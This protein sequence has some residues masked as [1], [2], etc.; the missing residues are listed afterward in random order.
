MNTSPRTQDSQA[1]FVSRKPASETEEPEELIY[2]IDPDDLAFL[3]KL[4]IP[5]E[6]CESALSKTGNRMLFVRE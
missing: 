3:I 6:K 4:G 5:E 2:E 1:N